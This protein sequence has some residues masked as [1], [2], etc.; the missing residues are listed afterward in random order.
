[1]CPR[2][3]FLQQAIP[4]ARDNEWFQGGMKI[5]SSAQTGRPTSQSVSLPIELVD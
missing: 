3:A 4:A 2:I 1:L 5:R